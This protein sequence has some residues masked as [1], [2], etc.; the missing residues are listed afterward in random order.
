MGWYEN[1]VRPDA[2]DW[3]A[4]AV[5][6]PPSV[7]TIVDAASTSACAT[8]RPE[9]PA[10]IEA[11]LRTAGGSACPTRLWSELFFKGVRATSTSV[12]AYRRGWDPGADFGA[13]AC[14]G[15]AEAAAR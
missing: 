4:S 12:H 14:G 10:A 3:L 2:S 5:L 9:V 13:V 15:A 8:S 7:D 11:C 6:V 1:A